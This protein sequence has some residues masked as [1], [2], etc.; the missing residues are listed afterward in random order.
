MRV[1]LNFRQIFG[2]LWPDMA[3]QRFGFSLEFLQGLT[4]A[5]PSLNLGQPRSHHGPAQ[6]S[7]WASPG[8]NLR[9]SRFQPG[10]S[11]TRA[12]PGLSPSQ[13]RSHPGPGLIPGQARF[14]HEPAEVL[15]GAIPGVSPGQ[16]Q[17][18]RA[19]HWLGHGQPL[20]AIL[21]GSELD[22]KSA[23]WAQGNSGLAHG[24]AMVGW[25]SSHCR[26]MV[27]LG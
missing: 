19:E 4:W 3:R 23:K 7:T 13:A 10:M 27:G 9:Q 21:V 17:A 25:W 20:P 1:T 16:S 24:R 12:R 5:R 26:A 6:D 22:P 18:T 2:N 11:Q 14:Q 15:A 8:F